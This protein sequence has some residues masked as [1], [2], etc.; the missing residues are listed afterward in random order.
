MR[1]KPPPVQQARSGGGKKRRDGGLRSL[2]CSLGPGWIDD[3]KAIWTG[4]WS[5]GEGQRRR[6]ARRKGGGIGAMSRMMV[7]R[8]TK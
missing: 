2:S 3:C 1:V 6:E 4:D 5:E 7:I 8:T